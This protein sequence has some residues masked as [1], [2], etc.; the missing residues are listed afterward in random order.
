[1]QDFYDSSDEEQDQCYIQPNKQEL[2]KFKIQQKHSN[3][4]DPEYITEP[5]NRQNYEERKIS[6]SKSSCGNQSLNSNSKS[7]FLLNLQNIESKENKNK[8]PQTKVPESVIDIF[9]EEKVVKI[10]PTNKA[11]QNAG[12]NDSIF[13]IEQ[14]SLD[15]IPSD[16]MHK[17]SSLK[18]Y[19][20][21]NKSLQQ[22]NLNEFEANPIEFDSHP[23]KKFTEEKKV[24]D[25]SDTIIDE[26]LINPNIKNI[27]SKASHNFEEID[28]W[29]KLQAFQQQNPK[30]KEVKK[31]ML[32]IEKSNT[33]N[34]RDLLKIKAEHHNTDQKGESEY[35]PEAEEQKYSTGQNV[36]KNASYKHSEVEDER[37][38]EDPYSCGIRQLKS[39]TAYK[40]NDEE[41]KSSKSIKAIKLQHSFDEL[42]N[43]K[44]NNSFTPEFDEFGGYSYDILQKVN[45]LDREEYEFDITDLYK[46]KHQIAKDS[47][48]DQNRKIQDS[49]ENMQIKNREEKVEKKEESNKLVE[50]LR[51]YK[52]SQQSDEDENIEN[53]EEKHGTPSQSKMN[54]TK[55]I[56][57]SVREEI[58]EMN[59]IN[60]NIQE[61][62]DDGYLDWQ[63]LN[64]SKQSSEILKPYLE[65][66]P[67]DKSQIDQILDSFNPEYESIQSRSKIQSKNQ[68]KSDEDKEEFESIKNER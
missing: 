18:N 49:H 33:L 9:P 1:M 57:A 26:S 68:L 53:D 5:L 16:Q 36:N 27:R 47:P 43:Q 8:I 19:E 15:S 46:F 14:P 50:S 41:V 55:A 2:L 21:S 60:E 44:L 24:C 62:R 32:S 4:E 28:E 34:P 39:S 48:I 61:Q 38:I 31:T 54:K 63:K 11:E 10:S 6:K 3:Q 52:E 22:Q 30:N 23:Y 45:F 17:F 12:E 64:E 7:W 40:E 59:K 51:S 29:G 25:A 66:E 58:K 13:H 35:D 42:L 67:L 20:Q 37:R 65:E 56:N